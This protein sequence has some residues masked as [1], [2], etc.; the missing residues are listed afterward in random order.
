MRNVLAVVAF[1]RRAP[2]ALTVVTAAAADATVIVKVSSTLLLSSFRRPL[3]VSLTK[4]ITSSVTALTATLA[5]VATAVRNSSRAVGMK[6]DTLPVTTTAIETEVVMGGGGIEGEG[7][8]AEIGGGSG[9]KGGSGEGCGGDGEGGD[10]AWQCSSPSET[11]G[12]G[13]D[14]LPK[15]A[16]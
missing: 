1:T 8:G 16:Q 15:R 11:N 3:A 13:C 4:G 2:S 5:W 10:G 7:S 14:A 12:V 6:S 9:G